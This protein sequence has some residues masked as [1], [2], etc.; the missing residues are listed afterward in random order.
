M[1]SRLWGRLVVSF[2]RGISLWLAVTSGV[3]ERRKIQEILTHMNT[4]FAS[5]WGLDP[6]VRSKHTDMPA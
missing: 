5:A 3:A 1:G 2:L 6:K 4:I